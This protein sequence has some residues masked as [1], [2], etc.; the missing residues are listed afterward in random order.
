MFVREHRKISWRITIKL[1]SLYIITGYNIKAEGELISPSE[2]LERLCATAHGCIALLYEFNVDSP[3]T[4]RLRLRL[5]LFL[6]VFSTNSHWSLN[7]LVLA[8]TSSKYLVWLSSCSICCRSS[9]VWASL[10]SRH[11]WAASLF[12]ILL[13]LRLSSRCG[14]NW[15]DKKE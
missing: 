1:P 4:T 15:K 12:L 3:D 2:L 8:M 5:Q 13:S 9:A 6:C 10:L 11:F 7:S 14:G